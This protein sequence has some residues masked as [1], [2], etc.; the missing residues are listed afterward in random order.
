LADLLG[1]D[2]SL[3]KN[4][5]G[6]ELKKY[7]EES[8]VVVEDV[9]PIVEKQIVDIKYLLNDLIK[10]IVEP[11]FSGLSEF[12]G[13]LEEKFEVYFKSLNGNNSLNRC[14]MI[15]N[16]VKCA[17]PDVDVDKVGD[18]LV[19]YY[20]K[21][22]GM[23]ENLINNIDLMVVTNELLLENKID[24]LND[25]NLSVGD[26]CE[27]YKMNLNDSVRFLKDLCCL[28]SK[29]KCNIVG[30]RFYFIKNLMFKLYS[31]DFEVNWSKFITIMDENLC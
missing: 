15:R 29:K 2:E 30:K 7:F 20:N 23:E 27:L 26:L 28:L 11:G 18:L 21:Y 5:I 10:C 19:K 8:V 24:C 1:R 14:E 3:V 17:P 13:S 22:A 31:N 4:L 16:L 9:K 12:D 6:N 25:I